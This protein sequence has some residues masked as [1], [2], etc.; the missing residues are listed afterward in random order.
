MTDTRRFGIEEEFFVVDAETKAVMR[1]MPQGFFATAKDRLG[2]RVKSEMLQ[3]QVELTSSIHS[4]ASAARNEVQA[5]RGTLGEVAA[6]HGL[7]ILGSG[8]HPPPCGRRSGRA[9]PRATTT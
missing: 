9:M 7:A 2:D 8:T 1:R 4:T 3:S 6:A 5:M